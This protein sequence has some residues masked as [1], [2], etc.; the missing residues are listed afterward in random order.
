VSGD[1]SSDVKWF[2]QNFPVETYVSKH[3]QEYMNA[4]FDKVPSTNKIYPVD[5]RVE[6]INGKLTFTTTDIGFVCIFGSIRQIHD[7]T[8]IF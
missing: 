6:E 5:F 3:I 2:M 7:R 8:D 1:K 4:I